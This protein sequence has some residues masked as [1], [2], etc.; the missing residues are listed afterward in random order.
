MFCII[1]GNMELLLLNLDSCQR[2]VLLS[3]TELHSF[4]EKVYWR[5]YTVMIIDQIELGTREAILTLRIV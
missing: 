3:C 5:K 4:V 1:S 2:S